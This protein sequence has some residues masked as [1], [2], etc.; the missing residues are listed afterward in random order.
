MEYNADLGLLVLRLAVG[1][2]IAPHGA[3]KLFGWF[4]GYGIKGTGGWLDSLGAKNGWVIALFAGLGEF[5]G[6]LGIA[7]GLFTPIAA[8]GVAIVMLG[9]I[10]MAHKGKGFFNTNGGWEFP[11]L[12]ALGA[13]AVAIAGPGAY[14]LATAWGLF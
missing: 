12:I 7:A 10:V 9:A 14:S 4:G 6:G 11:L 5:F 8:A 2:V 3:Q 13:L 1:L